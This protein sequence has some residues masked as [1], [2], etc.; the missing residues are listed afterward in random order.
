MV[1]AIIEVKVTLD[2]GLGYSDMARIISQFNEVETV[3]L[4]SGNYDFAVVV[5]C[6]DIKQVGGFVAKKLST[7]RG[8]TDVATHYVMECYKQAGE[9][10]NIA[11]DED[12]RGLYNV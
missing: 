11:E 12:D 4:M 3:Y 1:T 6:A 9:I 5:N 10:L 8:V 2:K 7:I